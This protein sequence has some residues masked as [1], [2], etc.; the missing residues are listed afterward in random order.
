M[1]YTFFFKKDSRILFGNFL[2]VL[3]NTC[4][5][6]RVIKEGFLGN[7]VTSYQT[8]Y[9]KGEPNRKQIALRVLL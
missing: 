6:I 3:E 9:S 1:N 7:F 2:S 8:L 5:K 4:K